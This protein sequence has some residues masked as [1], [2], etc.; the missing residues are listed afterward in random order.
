MEELLEPILE[1]GPDKIFI[2]LLDDELERVH[3]FYI[4]KVQGPKI[5]P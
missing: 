4:A 2:Q 1:D 5:T 3:T